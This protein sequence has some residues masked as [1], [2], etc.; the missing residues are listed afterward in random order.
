MCL[1][2]R[3]YISYI[4]CLKGPILTQVLLHELFI[5]CNQQYC[6]EDSDGGHYYLHYQVDWCSFQPRSQ[7]SKSELLTLA[8]FELMKF[9]KVED[10]QF[11]VYIPKISLCLFLMFV[12]P[13]SQTESITTFYPV[14]RRRFNLHHHLLYLLYLLTYEPLALPNL[15]SPM[16]LMICMLSFNPSRR[17]KCPYR[18]ML[19]LRMPPF[20]T[21]FKSNMT[22]FL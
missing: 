16:I 11:I 14:M 15:S 7:S 6:W 17:S 1:A 8:A 4:A 3:S 10:D 9:C 18:L 13:L 5:Q 12:E 19:N 21:L 2:C 20:V 22:R